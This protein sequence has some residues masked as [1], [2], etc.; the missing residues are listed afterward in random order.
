[1]KSL[2]LFI[3]V[4]VTT[5]L[6]SQN[7]KPSDELIQLVKWMEGDYNST[8]QS[9]NDSDYY[10]ITLH[11]KRIW[12]KEYPN[13]CWLYVEQTLTQTPEKPY[14]QRIYHV[15]QPE[16]ELFES[17]VLN[18]PND[19]LV[20]GAWKDESLL[21]DLTKES[22]ILKE[23]CSVYLN[24]NGAGIYEGSTNDRTCESKL[25]GASYA[26]SHV[27]VLFDRIISWDQGFDS[28]GKQVWGATKG[29]Y[30][31]IKLKM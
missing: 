25:R 12:V 22:L 31:F 17:M 21:K 19:S 20:I 30:Q 18:I 26:T 7:E 4:L 14:R 1:M 29:G 15:T 8:Q 27:T 16:E 9:E 2:F 28:E 10:S 24:Y 6:F 3:C 5:N 11:M 13:E 23:G